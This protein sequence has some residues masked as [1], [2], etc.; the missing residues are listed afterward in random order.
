M[1]TPNHAPQSDELLIELMREI[2]NG[3]MYLLRKDQPTQPLAE[4]QS[5]GLQTLK[6][7]T[8]A[9]WEL[10]AKQRFQAEAK[11]KIAEAERVR[12]ET[13]RIRVQQK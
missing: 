8:D 4:D 6:K 10:A 13:E 1:S 7:M 9:S 2:R 12:A 5:L 3:V 11:L